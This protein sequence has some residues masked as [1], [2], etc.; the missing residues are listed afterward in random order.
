MKEKLFCKNL[1]NLR[2]FNIV[3]RKKKIA[4]SFFCSKNFR[5]YLWK[6][7]KLTQLGL[8]FRPFFDKRFLRRIFSK[9]KLFYFKLAFFHQIVFTPIFYTI[10]FCFLHQCFYFY[11]IICVFTPMFLFLHHYLRFYT[12]FYTNFFSNNCFLNFKIRFKKSC[13]KMVQK[14]QNFWCKKNA[15]AKI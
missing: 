15:N 12:I 14:K 2:I 7:V 9:K 10:F 5:K 4:G 11:T 1:L 3:F 6:N 13:K 8:N